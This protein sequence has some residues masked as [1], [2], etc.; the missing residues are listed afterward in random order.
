[1][2]DNKREIDLIYDELDQMSEEELDREM[3]KILAEVD[4]D[5]GLANVE[6]PKG[7]FEA[8]S[9]EIQ[10]TENQKARDNLSEED[11]ELLYYGKLYKRQMKKRKYFVLAAILI[12]SLAVGITSM[13]GP[14][15]LLQKVPG[16]LSGREQEMV[17]ANDGSIS[18]TTGWTEEEAYAEI[19]KKF[20]FYPV[21]FH[22]LPENVGFEEMQIYDEIQ[23]VQLLY[24]KNDEILFIII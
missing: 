6:V 20:G 22:Y 8:V 16:T 18:N 13:G 9:K 19:E 24:S 7:L 23:G 17:D 4:A 2:K 11:K 1:M 3:E 12:L 5:E 14:R 10:Q 15:K 21:K